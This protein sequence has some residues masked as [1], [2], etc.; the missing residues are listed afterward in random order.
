MKLKSITATF[1]LLLISFA[2]SAQEIIFDRKDGMALTMTLIKPEKPNGKAIISLLS[3]G[4]FSDHNLFPQYKE[5]TK[6]FTDA[7]Y[8]VFLAGHRSVSRYT[9]PEALA[10]VQKAVQFVRY[11]ASEYGI[12]P[13]KIGITG[14]SSGGHLSLLAAMSDD[15]ADT[16]AKDPIDKTSSK[17]QAVAV[18]CPPTDFTNYGS[19]G[20]SV[21]KMTGWLRFLRLENGFRYTIWDDKQQAHVPIPDQDLAKTDA[22]MSPALQVTKDDPPTYISHGDKDE[23]VP[24]QQ[25]EI[26]ISALKNSGIPAELAVKKGAGHGWADMNQDEAGFVSWFDTY[27]K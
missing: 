1:L 5:R 19:A 16:S 25:S 23:L 26:M 21:R 12:D 17:V 18:F 22:L 10:D 2:V 24:L 27:L 20:N 14:T 11:H 15:I 13:N 8:T 9:V 7:G 4:F 6:P 3:G